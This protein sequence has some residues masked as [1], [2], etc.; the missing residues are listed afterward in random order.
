MMPRIVQ[1]DPA[2]PLFY[3]VGYGGNGVSYSA[4][5]GRRLAELVAGRPARHAVP[6]FKGAA[7]GP[8]LCA[9]PPSGPAHALPGLPTPRRTAGP[10]GRGRLGY[11]VAMEYAM[12][13][14]AG[15]LRGFTGFGFS[16]AAV[17]LL[18]LIMPPARAIPIVL[19]LQLLVSIAGL[20]DAVRHCDWRSIRMLTVGAAVATP[21][22]V[23]GLAHLSA[24]PVRLTIAVVVVCGAL[25]LGRGFRLPIVPVGWRV[26]PFGLASGLFNGLAGIP[27]PPVI[28][29]YLASPVSSAVARS[30]MIVFFLLTAV[31]ALVPLAWLGLLPRKPSWSRPQ[32]G[33]PGGAGGFV[34]RRPRLWLQRGPALPVRGAGLPAG[35][36]GAVRLARRIRLR[37]VEKGERPP[38]LTPSA[39][40][41]PHAS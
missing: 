19:I 11:A 34:A 37:R 14:L 31:L 41:R 4:Q 8:R 18:S 12:L 17:P 22:G 33:F 26:L 27:G 5:A 3:A 16:L 25:V 24:A 28:A 15:A 13:F 1:P 21:L 40:S 32:F 36:G 39:S 7:A 6:I 30:S 29:F 2:E 20:R 9:V 10:L 38:C 35:D 23:W